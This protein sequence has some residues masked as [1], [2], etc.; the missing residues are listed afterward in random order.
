MA[1]LPGMDL[2]YFNFRS[3]AVNDKDPSFPFLFFDLTF[4]KDVVNL[5]FIKGKRVAVALC[6]VPVTSCT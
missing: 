6:E 5:V 4:P 3:R 1:K 2:K